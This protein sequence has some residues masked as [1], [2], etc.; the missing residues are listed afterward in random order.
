MRRSTVKSLRVRIELPLAPEENYRKK[1]FYLNP[2]PLVVTGCDADEAGDDAASIDF[3]RRRFAVDV[4]HAGVK[5]RQSKKTRMA[6]LLDENMSWKG[7]EGV[8]RQGILK[9][10]VSLYH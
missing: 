6:R 8:L 3:R 10:E 1:S 7:F 4:V 2:V 5:S 9:G